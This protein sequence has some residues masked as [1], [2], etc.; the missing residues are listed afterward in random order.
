MG[1]T[2]LKKLIF[3]LTRERV[4]DFYEAP[5][6]KKLNSYATLSYS[7]EGEDLILKRIFEG[8]Q[9]GFFVDVGAH[10]PQRF[11]NTYLFYQMGWRGIN[12]DATPG[13]M[14]KFIEQ[15]PGDINLEI[16]ISDFDEISTFYKFNEPAL[17]TFSILEA[18]KKH[19]TKNYKIID[20]VMI[21]T[22]TLTSVLDE[23]KENHLEIDFLNIDVEGYDYKV[24][25][26][27]DWKKYN[28][29]IIL[30][31]DLEID[32]ENILMNEICTFLR[33]L[34]YILFAKTYNTLIFKRRMK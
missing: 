23:W 9:G 6:K 25:K 31:E 30:I 7:Q 24:L 15:R 32:L 20:K 8:K 11:S 3:K 22:R 2:R 21:R 33:S 14:N 10:H 5:V 26:S 4:L 17:N 13:S 34:D 28:P 1:I 29:Q 27:L 18:Q 12:I 16:A 19:G